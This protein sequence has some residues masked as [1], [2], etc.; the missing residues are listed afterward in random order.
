MCAWGLALGGLASPGQPDQ[1]PP[2]SSA[3]RTPAA[4]RPPPSMK[5]RVYRKG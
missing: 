5:P 2:G 4:G 3:R 1:I